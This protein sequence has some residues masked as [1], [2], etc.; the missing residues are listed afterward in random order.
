MTISRILSK[1]TSRAICQAI[2][3]F[4]TH[5]FEASSPNSPV[6]AQWSVLALL[7]GAVAAGTA[8]VALEEIPAVNQILPKQ[9]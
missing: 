6:V 4:G 8:T 5:N 3:K 9:K 2:H 7:L 1:R